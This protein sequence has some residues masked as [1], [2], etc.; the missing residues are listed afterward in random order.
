METLAHEGSHSFLFGLTM[1][2]P[3]VRNPDDE[4]F[5]SP[6]RQDRRPMDGIYHATYVSA[7]MYYALDQAKRSGLLDEAQQAECE[8]RMRDSARAF[9][10]GATRWSP[11][12]RI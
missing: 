12:M 10:G 1:E 9:S 11:P 4:L 6:L 8:A 3:L 5:P 2:E 7:R